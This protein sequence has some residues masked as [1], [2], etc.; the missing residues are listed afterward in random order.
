MSNVQITGLFGSRYTFSPITECSVGQLHPQ[1]KKTESSVL[2]ILFYLP[3]IFLVFLVILKRNILKREKET[4]VA[5]Y[6]SI[7][8]TTAL[9]VH[10][11]A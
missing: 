7:F 5:A 9:E 6:Y 3:Y 1:E 8:V 10:V 4:E 11:L 2:S